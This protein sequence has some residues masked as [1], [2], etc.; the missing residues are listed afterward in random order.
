[1]RGKMCLCVPQAGRVKEGRGRCS[2]R[3]RTYVVPTAHGGEMPK[4]GLGGSC[5]LGH[6]ASQR[7]HTTK[8]TATTP[9]F[10]NLDM[11]HSAL[12]SEAPKL[13][14]QGGVR[15]G[16]GNEV[17]VQAQRAGTTVLL[18]SRPQGAGR[19]ERGGGEGQVRQCF[20]PL[21]WQSCVSLLFCH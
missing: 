8:T 16:R 20:C 11:S 3:G 21:G 5:P 6:T 18:W 19:S 9:I 15:Q 10:T 17:S 13:A 2:H 7:S 14:G 12:D 4:E 1:M